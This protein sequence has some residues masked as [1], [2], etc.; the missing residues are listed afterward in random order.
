MIDNLK[1]LFN[2]FQ[3][4]VQLTANKIGFKDAFTHVIVYGTLTDL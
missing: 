1:A 3:F 4:E 2:V